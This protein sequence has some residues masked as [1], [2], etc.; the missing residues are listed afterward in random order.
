MSTRLRL[1]TSAARPLASDAEVA[2]ALLRGDKDAPYLA[3]SHFAPF[4]RGSLRR[5]LGPGVDEDDLSQE[6][7]LRFFPSVRRLRDLEAIRGFLFGVCVRVGRKELRRRWLRRWLRLTPEGVL[8]EPKP[9]LDPSDGDA[10]EVLGRYYAIL[11]RVGGQA[12][13]LY[14]TRYIQDLDLVEVARLHGL[15]LSTTQRKLARITKR[16][17]AMVRLDP[18]LAEFTRAAHHGPGEGTPS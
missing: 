13:S 2:A 1:V 14:V 15:S 17:E 18:L 8:P 16:I 7:F 5:L 6:V 12:R 3:W 9:E 10:P 4:V 11:D